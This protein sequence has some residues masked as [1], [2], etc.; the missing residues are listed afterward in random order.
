MPDKEESRKKFLSILLLLL[1]L[2][3]T[4]NILNNLNFLIKIVKHH[5]LMNKFSESILYY[6]II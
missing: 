1:L 5:I 3:L 4:L 6:I 2:L